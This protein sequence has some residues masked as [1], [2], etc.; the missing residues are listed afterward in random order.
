MAIFDCFMQLINLGKD[1]NV[2]S[3]EGTIYQDT[4]TLK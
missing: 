4:N 2:V 3:I 1:I